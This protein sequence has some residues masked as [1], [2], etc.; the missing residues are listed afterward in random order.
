MTLQ[1]R[2]ASPGH[3]RSHLGLLA[4]AVLAM[5]ATS[6]DFL[7]QDMFATE[8]QYLDGTCDLS[9]IVHAKTGY[10]FQSINTIRQLGSGSLTILFVLCNTDTSSVLLMLDPES[11][12]CFG[13][14]EG[15]ST[16]LGVDGNGYYCAGNR[17]FPDTATWSPSTISVV[18]VG[19]YP[20][21]LPSSD[22]TINKNIL[23][24]LYSGSLHM[25]AAQTD[26]T[27]N[28]SDTGLAVSSDGSSSWNLT[29]AALGPDGTCRLLLENDSLAKTRL[30]EYST[31]FALYTAL[32]TSTYSYLLDIGPSM[33]LGISLEDGWLLDD[34]LVCVDNDNDNDKHILRYDISDGQLMD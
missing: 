11:L 12:E 21:L 33:T 26:W 20:Y 5:M 6:C 32:S 9:A 22:A 10:A 14:L 25:M 8:L 3:H 17:Y 13:Y 27:L 34:Y 1:S 29:D 2:F 16:P 4:A 24:N 28:L 31:P 30:V 23:F 18:P 15:A 7:M 19:N